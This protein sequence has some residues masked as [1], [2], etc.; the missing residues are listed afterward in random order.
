MCNRAECR[1]YTCAPIAAEAPAGV[2][3]CPCAPGGPDSRLRNIALRRALS[4]VTR[5]SR[6]VEGQALRNRDNGSVRC[7]CLIDELNGHF[8]SRACHHLRR[9][10]RHDVLGRRAGAGRLRCG[11]EFE[12]CNEPLNVTRP[13]HDLRDGC[14]PFEVRTLGRMLI[15]SKNQI[16]AWQR[17]HVANGPTGTA[18]N[19][20]K[21][22][23]FGFRRFCPHSSVALRRG[24]QP[25]LLATITPH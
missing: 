23:A 6:V 22:I 1:A 17:A 19:L 14:S 13:D 11:P 20:I 16:A 9:R 8:R 24:I 10:H 4:T 18:D 12:G 7:Q 2:G 5:S 15:H 3:G 25:D 21:R